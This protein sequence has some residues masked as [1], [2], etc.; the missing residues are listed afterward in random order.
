MEALFTRSG[1]VVTD[2]KSAN[3]LYSKHYGT[4]MS[5]KLVL[6]FVEAFYLMSKGLV[7]KYK[8]KTLTDSEFLS[9]VADKAFIVKYTVYSD[10]KSRGYIVKTAFKYGADFRVYKKG[11]KPGKHHSDWLVFCFKES[12]RIPL[13]QYASMIRV[14]HSVKKK[15]LVAIVDDEMDVVYYECDW[16]SL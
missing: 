4:M 15:A 9:K 10:L 2:S 8:D 7:V 3:R 5:G 12:E 11:R 1:V 6:S 13:S 14:T 16:V